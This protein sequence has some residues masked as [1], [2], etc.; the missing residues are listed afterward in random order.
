MSGVNLYRGRLAPSPTGYLHLGHA[1]T[2][3]VAW[4]RARQHAGTLVLRNE[5][6]DRDRCRPE[7]VT[8]MVED[9]RWLGLDWQ[10]GP[11]CGGPHAP[12]DQ[13]RR[14]AWH[15][16]VF[17]QLRSSGCVYPCVCSRKDVLQALGAPH[18]GEEEPVYPGTCRP[19]KRPQ[20][21][22]VTDPA[23]LRHR[24][25]H[26]RRVNWR[27]RVPDG[28]RI[29]FADG[30]AGPQEFVA[31]RDFGDFVVWRHDDVP[32]YQLAVVADDHAMGITEV[33]R[34]ADLLLSTARQLLLYHA[35]GWT[36]PQF[37]HVPLM[38]DER[39]TRLAK[40]HDALSLR[41]LRAAG[42]HPAEWGAEWEAW[43]AQTLPA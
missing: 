32:A 26:G 21:I 1:R 36:P 2:F 17:E 11:D 9:L 38:T 24:D 27:F 10:E 42:A 23:R 12:Y 25:A 13:S 33:V 8:A 28:E 15:V 4:H 30:A 5:D 43:L 34:G 40:R 18:A 37:F 6:L 39:G 7:Y 29:T 3:W 35:L 19:E 41:A 14:H 31:G 16:A 22:V 20:P